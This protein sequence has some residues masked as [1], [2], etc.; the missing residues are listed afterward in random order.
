VEEQFV[1][2]ANR[3]SD[4]ADQ[5]TGISQT[6]NSTNGTGIYGATFDRRL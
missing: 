5:P 4:E 3:P 2:P 6:S 1:D